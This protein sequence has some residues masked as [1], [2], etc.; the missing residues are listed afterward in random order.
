MLN[1]FWDSRLI[2]CSGEFGSRDQVPLTYCFV[3]CCTLS[4]GQR[5]FITTLPGLYPIG[6]KEKKVKSRYFLSRVKVFNYEIKKFHKLHWLEL[7]T[8][9][10]SA[11]EGLQQKF[12][13]KVIMYPVEIQKILVLRGKRGGQMLMASGCLEYL[14]HSLNKINPLVLIALDLGFIVPNPKS[15]NKRKIT[16]TTLSFSYIF[17]TRDDWS[18]YQVLVLMLN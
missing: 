13:S 11:A 9:P 14:F 5:W 12:S 10:Y 7:I 16:W 1:S 8:W 4:H 15:R 3:V 17:L 2:L 18:F 6:K